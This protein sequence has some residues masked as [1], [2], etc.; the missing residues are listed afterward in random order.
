MDDPFGADQLGVIACDPTIYNPP[1]SARLTGAAVR[2][3]GTLA[4]AGGEGLPRSLDVVTAVT[5]DY[6]QRA[7]RRNRTQYRI[8]FTIQNPD[9]R[10]TQLYATFDCTPSALT[11][12][13]T[14]LAP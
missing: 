7:A 2:R 3:I 6:A 13:L 1:T 4:M 5:E 8:A 10:V 14:Y 12:T 9:L 11:L